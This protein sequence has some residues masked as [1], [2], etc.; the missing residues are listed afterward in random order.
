MDEKVLK[1]LA[2]IESLDSVVQQENL[3]IEG[4]W[5]GGHLY[6]EP[7][8]IICGW[9]SDGTEVIQIASAKEQRPMVVLTVRQ[10]LSLLA[11]LIRRGLLESIEHDLQK[12]L[13]MVILHCANEKWEKKTEE[14]KAVWYAKDMA[15]EE[16]IRNK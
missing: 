5:V 10:F 3:I 2:K 11:Y 14:E 15:E 1:M 13:A 6:N 12:D 8:R 4:G 9:R 16:A 7:L